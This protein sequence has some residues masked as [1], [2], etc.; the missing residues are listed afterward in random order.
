MTLKP[1]SQCL[2]SS[3]STTSGMAS[4][5]TTVEKEGHE[6]VEG[7]WNQR[8]RFVDAPRSTYIRCFFTL[9]SE[10]DSLSSHAATSSFRPT[11]AETSLEFANLEGSQKVQRIISEILRVVFSQIVIPAELV[12]QL[13]IVVVLEEASGGNRCAL[14]AKETQAPIHSRGLP[15]RAIHMRKGNAESQ[16]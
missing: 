3:S 1:P 4:T 11:Y 10:R 14:I 2:S 15:S 12:E 7:F 9:Q 16:S 13:K 5:T 8:S 6:G